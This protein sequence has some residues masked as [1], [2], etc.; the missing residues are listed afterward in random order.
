MRP[1][2]LIMRSTTFLLV[3]AAACGGESKRTTTAGSSALK[4][5]AIG[6]AAPV[7]ELTDVDGR[8]VSLASLKGSVVVLNVWATWCQPCRL[9]TPEL[10]ALHKTYA[11]Q[12]VRVVG[13]SID[14]AGAG[15][16]V[17]AFATEFVVPYDLWLD[18]Q[19]EV[20]LRFLT[21]G[22]PETFVIDRQGVIRARQIGGVR[23]GDT[24]V[25][26]AIKRAL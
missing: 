5:P 21:I 6:A 15:P 13:V 11:G 9:E 16:D 23:A 8:P 17:Q 20:Q 24:L 26:S 3:L 10:V 25:V 2:Q 12:G 18:P 1:V 4:A 7:L 19:K 22:V 14:N